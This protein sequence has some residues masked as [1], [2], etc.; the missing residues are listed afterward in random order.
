MN[1]QILIIPILNHVNSNVGI[2]EYK[3]VDLIVQTPTEKLKGNA[4]KHDLF[5]MFM[6]EFTGQRLLV[7][8]PNISATKQIWQIYSVNF[9]EID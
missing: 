1:I 2:V 9:S 6:S 3:Y 7:T 4:I 8:Y 5:T